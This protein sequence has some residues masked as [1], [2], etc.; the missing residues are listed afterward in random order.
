MLKLK[1]LFSRVMSIEPIQRQSIVSF[2]WQMA[3]AFIGFLS[4][5][6]IARTVGA[7]VVG[8]YFLFLAYF[9]IIGF[10][11]D[12]GFS[13]AA[14]K[15]ISEGEEQNEYFSAFFVLRSVFVMVI[16]VALVAFRS[17]FV[18]M[19]RAGTFIW[20]LVGLIV[21]LLYGA[22]SAGIAGCGKIGI[23]ATADFIN[24]VSR[25]IV[26][27]VAVFLGYG[28]A[29]LIG[30]F[31]AGMFVGSIVNLRFFDLSFVRFGWRHI[32]NLSIFSFWV[33]LIS[34]GMIVYQSSDTIMIGYFLNNTDVGVYR[35]VL[36]FTTI[37]AFTTAAI[38]STL[39][40]KVSRWGI[41]G[42]IDLIGKSLSHA[43]TYSL[44]LA[45]PMFAGGILLGDKL[46][47]FF[48][49]AEFE[50][51]YVIMVI[52]F[53]V[54][55]VNIFHIFFTSYLSALDHIKDLFKIT[56]VAV[57]ANIT[58]NAAL[59]PIIGIV[60]AA[61][62]TLVTMGLNAILAKRVLSKIIT[63]RI[64]IHILLNILKASA[65]MALFVGI[66]RMLVPL[67]NVWVALVPVVLG[68]VVYGVLVLKF[69][70]NI[71]EELK[72]IVLHDS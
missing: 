68:A 14:G 50:Q 49:G 17:Y 64:E 70:K 57:T 29:G 10:F 45:I 19:D 41:T 31:I 67:S 52:L 9:G 24:N 34:S 51:G 20:L 63:I 71:Y 69:D 18:D 21:S 39:W 6:Y 62:A 2:T 38:S 8:G 35:I 16:V 22:L 26:Q 12:G 44:I 65:V 13:S 56:L 33:F 59:I 46:L 54:Q 48:Y 1:T 60:G 23:K 15:R 30:G 25:I 37:A 11:T 42:E 61:V 58:L 7:S 27:V 55:I 40:P 36:Q 5:M 43:F 47:Y 28:V 32:K 72:K 53:I 4:T 66:Y 3:Y